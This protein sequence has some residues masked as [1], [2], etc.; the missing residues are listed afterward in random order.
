MRVE[1]VR[2]TNSSLSTV[3]LASGMARPEG[4]ILHLTIAFPTLCTCHSF[5]LTAGTSIN[6][7]S[8]LTHTVMV[9][10]MTTFNLRNKLSRM[11]FQIRYDEN[12]R[13]S[14]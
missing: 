5:E 14:W 10:H 7:S 9:I 3:A 8:I 1:T 6:T 12:P 4:T 13:P 2:S 11:G